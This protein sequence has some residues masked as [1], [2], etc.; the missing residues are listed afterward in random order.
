MDSAWTTPPLLLFALVCLSGVI[1]VLVLV[2]IR[3]P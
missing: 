1:L 2:T 3:R